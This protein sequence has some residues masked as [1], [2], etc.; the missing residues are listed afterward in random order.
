MSTIDNDH[1]LKMLGS[2]LSVDDVKLASSDWAC[3]E[4]PEG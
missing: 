3:T 2:T 1:F 4:K